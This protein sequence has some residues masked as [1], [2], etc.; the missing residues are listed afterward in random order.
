[1]LSCTTIR[2]E[3]S[4]RLDTVR[5]LLTSTHSAGGATE[6]E[7]AKVSRGLA[8]VLIYAS[9]EQLLVSLV[10]AILEVAA[11]LGVGNRRLRPGFQVFAAFPK[12]QA[13]N[14]V[15]PA[16]I[17]SGRGLDVVSVI[18]ARNT[19]TIVAS[20]FPDNG[21][22]MKREQVRVLCDLFEL[23]DPAPVLRE[24]WTRLN[25]IVDER[26]AVAHGR[27]TPDEVGR[28]YSLAEL[29]TLVDLWQQR[30]GEFL[31]LVEALAAT[32]DFYRVAR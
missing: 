24:I 31:D 6:T 16:A 21:S 15:T 12:L 29:Q 9:Y 30:W 28:N 14:A 4:D 7:V 20:V 10:R 5:N 11:G 27:Q 26:N 17:W 19:C 22:H 13:T 2:A 1:M 23:G 18:N 32:R 8:I 3:L 25:T